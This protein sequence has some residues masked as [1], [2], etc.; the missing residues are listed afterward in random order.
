MMNAHTAVLMKGLTNDG[1]CTHNQR[2]G[3]HG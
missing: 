3:P 2:G 1:N